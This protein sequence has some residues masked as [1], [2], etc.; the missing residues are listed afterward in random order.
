LIKTNAFE[1]VNLQ[2]G[3]VA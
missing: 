1:F 2:G 3:V